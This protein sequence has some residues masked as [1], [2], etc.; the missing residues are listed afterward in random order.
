MS[1]GTKAFLVAGLFVTAALVLLVSPWASSQ[2][3][4]LERVAIDRGFSEDARP[5]LLEDGPV[6]GYSV[7]GVDDPKLSTAMS[8]L[9]GVTLTFGLGLGLFTVI[10]RRETKTSGAFEDAP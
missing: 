8:G 6:S 5:H 10:R 9:L 3:D 7:E 4:G 2:P 1:S